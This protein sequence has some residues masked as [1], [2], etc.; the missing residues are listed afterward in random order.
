MP[1]LD[2]A[3]DAARDIAGPGPGRFARLSPWAAVSEARW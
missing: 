3:R 1:A 2:T